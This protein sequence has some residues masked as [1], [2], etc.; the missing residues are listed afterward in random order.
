MQQRTLDYLAVA[1][2]LQPS[3]SSLPHLSL[4]GDLLVSLCPPCSTEATVT[5]TKH[6]MLGLLQVN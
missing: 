3:F 2:K 5:V 4:E 1:I 6:W